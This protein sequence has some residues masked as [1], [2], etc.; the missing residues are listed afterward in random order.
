[1]KYQWKKRLLA[2]LVSLSILASSSTM[3]LAATYPE[4]P[5]HRGTVANLVIGNWG[6][7]GLEYL[8]RGV[9]RGIGAAA[10]HTDGAMSDILKFTKKILGNP[11]ST[12]L[13][14]I[15]ALC[16]QIMNQI[17][18][19]QSNI[20][21]TTASLEGSIQHL[22]GTV[23]RN[24]YDSYHNQLVSF[25]NRY[26]GVYNDFLA[27]TEALDAYTKDPSESRLKTLRL[28][29]E[30]VEGFYNNASDSHTG[31]EFNFTSDLNAA[32]QLISPYPAT[33]TVNADIAVSDKRG[34]GS[35]TGSTTFLDALR[36][37][38]LDGYA[39]EHDIYSNMKS[40]MNE[41]AG[42]LSIYLSAYRLYTEFG[43]QRINSDPALTEKEKQNQINTLWNDFSNNSYRAMR[44]IE[45]MMS[46]YNADLAGYMREYDV[47]SS[48]KMSY[49]S[50]RSY[51]QN[52]WHPDH[53]VSHS[54]D[55][56][57]E[58]TQ[59]IVQ[60]YQVR[61]VGS[62]TAYAIL[63]SDNDP[64]ASK[65]NIQ[66][67]ANDLVSVALDLRY[68][69]ARALNA[70]FDNLLSSSSPS[71]Y[72]MPKSV[73]D[74]QSLLNVAAYT[75]DAS[76]GQHLV[77][78]LKSQG[79]TNLPNITKT[80]GSYNH[81]TLKKG[82][83]MLMDTKR[84]W[85][86]SNTMIPD[87]QDMDTTFLNVELPLY[88]DNA[89][90]NQVLIDVE[91][92]IYDN[93]G[94]YGGKE[95]LV[96]LSGTPRISFFSSTVGNGTLEIY[97]ADAEGNPTGAAFNPSRE[98][99]LSGTPM[100][101]KVRPG[102]NQ[103]LKSLV[104]T[105]NNGA[106]T[107]DLVG[108]SINGSDTSAEELLPYLQTDKDGYYYFHLPVPYQDARV[109]ATFGAPD[110]AYKTYTVDLA[111]SKEGEALF[112][113]SNGM[114]SREFHAGDTVELNV[115]PYQGKLIDMVT[116]A[117]TTGRNIRISNITNEDL[118]TTPTSKSYRFEMP[119]EAVIVNVTYRDGH[120]VSLSTANNGTIAFTGIACSN[121][122]W[123]NYP[124]TY[125]PGDT[126]QIELQPNDGY[127]IEN[128]TV[129]G[130]TSY[131]DIPAIVNNTVL[132]FKMPKENVTVTPAFAQIISGLH[133]ATIDCTGSGS[134]K[135]IEHGVG[136][137][138]AER[139]YK[140]GET[141]TFTAETFG[142]AVLES[143][144]VKE[145]GGNELELTKSKDTYSFTMGN[146]NVTIS[147][148]FTPYTVMTIKSTDPSQAN[149]RFADGTP[150]ISG[151]TANIPP[152]QKTYIQVDY[153][154]GADSIY[155]IIAVDENRKP[156][157]VKKESSIQDGPDLYSIQTTSKNV[158]ISL[159][160]SYYKKVKLVNYNMRF[161]D[162]GNENRV[163]GKEVRVFVPSATKAT[164]VYASDGHGILIRLT[165]HSYEYFS[166]IMPNRDVFVYKE[167]A[168][169]FKLSLG[170]LASSQLQVNYKNLAHYTEDSGAIFFEL[171]Q[172][173]SI[174]IVVPKGKTF[175]LSFGIFDQ[176]NLPIAVNKTVTRLEDGQ[177][178]YLFEFV[179][180]EQP[181]RIEYS[182]VQL[183]QVDTQYYDEQM[184]KYL[185]INQQTVRHGECAKR[186]DAPER[187]GK[188]FVDWQIDSR[189]FDWKT[190]IEGDITLTAI[191]KDYKAGSDQNTPDTA[192]QSPAAA[193][194]LFALSLGTLLILKKIRQ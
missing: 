20:Y 85:S 102:D 38:L 111:S 146:R 90:Q 168:P 194:L 117:T 25:Y 42:Y 56:S 68:S 169:G 39:F 59:E 67:V 8:E 99:L 93:R 36:T 62:N 116:A 174:E 188:V 134:L 154:I 160:I 106:Y 147:A 94:S 119:D 118:R 135:F 178:K 190:P 61:P 18:A 41:A 87:N 184:G 3:T 78:F 173:L 37:Y 159:K 164:N 69:D 88:R 108:G 82:A 156:I 10:S 110:R 126:V 9:M 180:K 52:V 83:F 26:L 5:S 148:Q 100:V 89:R 77:T 141:V 158:E 55:F 114:I 28:S 185:P 72:Y 153:Y 129:I 123:L 12:A 81:D 44:G 7:I 30:K 53:W 104:L 161:V 13:G 113:G 128:C 4:A 133:T 17:Y 47:D 138:T 49:Q 40:G 149:I 170:N 73:G 80:T 183:H 71:W 127:Y 84:E 51:K 136:I 86:P 21:S 6:A 101:A 45:Q 151:S 163:P 165:Y 74:I 143:V 65:N 75:S 57:A 24:N 46:L 105:A 79:L 95:V 137:N 172:P 34:W 181:L 162:G 109:T 182:E 139:S 63:K 112:A 140:N 131:D 176:N 103:V 177:T 191:Y 16:E 2:V 171:D 22:Q 76:D 115:R 15:R 92:D 50:S 66:L 125:A 179:G 130:Q 91:G 144:T 27:M 11:Q 192:D 31:T 35:S 132:Q 189:S 166:F 145:Y 58:K 157:S 98:L 43:A 121:S 33:Q 96:M 19:L 120:T 107:V 155:E 193:I 150:N 152:N 175:D 187:P 70:D 23:D 142:D 1:M 60:V 48:I 97:Q 124:I 29:Y 64:D 186:V 54:Y 32:L 167:G 14:E 122:E